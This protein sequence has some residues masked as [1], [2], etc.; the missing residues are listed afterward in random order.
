MIKPAIYLLD[1]ATSSL[2]AS[3]EEAVERALEELGKTSTI[4]TIAHRLNTVQNADWI[5][6]LDNG[7]VVNQGT[8]ELLVRETHYQNLINAYRQ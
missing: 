5:V 1:E 7:E 3:S 8:H 2:D 6:V 4:V